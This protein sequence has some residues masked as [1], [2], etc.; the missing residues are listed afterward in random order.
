M[1]H[2]MFKI[3]CL[4]SN[5]S[6]FWL[7]FTRLLGMVL[8][9]ILYCKLLMHKLGLL[10]I[11]LI[12]SQILR[13]SMRIRTFHFNKWMERKR[14]LL[15]ILLVVVLLFLIFIIIIF[16]LIINLLLIELI[17]YKY[18]YWY[19]CC[20][21]NPTLHNLLQINK[22]MKK[23]EKV[24]QLYYCNF[25]EKWETKLYSE[26]PAYISIHCKCLF[27]KHVVIMCRVPLPSLPLIQFSVDHLKM[28]FENTF[29]MHK[30]QYHNHLFGKF[31]IF[32]EWHQF[33]SILCL[34]LWNAI[35]YLT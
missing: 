11:S 10:D 24:Q 13:S 6:H 33:T 15:E 22:D 17:N 35:K 29:T 4:F 26:L 5:I 3:P 25:L 19:W 14:I 28:P 9:Y 23:S 1:S 34:D 21:L 31:S 16:I 12:F 32:Q 20:L 30:H 8:H 2:S 7:T 27:N 18:S